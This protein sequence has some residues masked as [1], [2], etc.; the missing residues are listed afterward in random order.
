MTRATKKGTLGQALQGKV[1]D[2]QPD[3]SEFR[4]QSISGWA[5]YPYQP[6]TDFRAGSWVDVPVR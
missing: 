5:R 2:G 1:L 4:R 6:V 3:R